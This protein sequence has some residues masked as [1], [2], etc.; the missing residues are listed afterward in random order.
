LVTDS[1]SIAARW[2]KYFFQLFNVHRVNDV[3]TDRHTYSRNISA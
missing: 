2:R 1:H 3:K